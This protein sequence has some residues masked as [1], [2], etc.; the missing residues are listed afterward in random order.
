MQQGNSLGGEIPPNSP[1]AA[2]HT[3]AA[4][5]AMWRNSSPE[6]PQR[7]TSP[8]KL[9]V[10]TSNSPGSPTRVSVLRTATRQSW[11]S[12]EQLSRAVLR[13]QQQHK[14]FE[15]CAHSCLYNLLAPRHALAHLHVLC[16][17][18]ISM[19]LVVAGCQL[20]KAMTCL[21]HTSSSISM[22]SFFRSSGCGCANPAD[23]LAAYRTCKMKHQTSSLACA[24][25]AGYGGGLDMGIKPPGKSF[26]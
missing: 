11:N 23:G 8:T 26:G 10:R 15:V 4:A 19:H 18:D 1:T 14:A 22:G 12:Q 6:P 20:G 21:M 7:S 5:S 2:L 25:L 16:V 13:Q 9:G 17:Q 24:M 3:A